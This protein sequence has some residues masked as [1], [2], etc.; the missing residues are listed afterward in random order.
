MSPVGSFPFE[1]PLPENRIWLG[2]ATRLRCGLQ[3]VQEEA[4]GFQMMLVTLDWLFDWAVTTQSVS[5]TVFPGLMFAL[6]G[7]L[8]RLWTPE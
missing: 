2:L 5:P 6:Q 8:Q 4:G 1:S 7:K 3:R